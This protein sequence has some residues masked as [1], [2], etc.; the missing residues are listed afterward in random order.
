MLQFLLLKYVELFLVSFVLILF[1]AKLAMVAIYQERTGDYFSNNM[2]LWYTNADFQAS[3]TSRHK[4]MHRANK[5]GA[6]LWIGGLLLAG[7]VLLE[8]YSLLR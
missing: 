8:K 6:A 2:I 1:I 3:N 5:V 4:V 7:L